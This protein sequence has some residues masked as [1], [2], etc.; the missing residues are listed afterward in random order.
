MISDNEKK[1]SNFEFVKVNSN[2]LYLRCVVAN[3]YENKIIEFYIDK[4]LSITR[5]KYNEESD[6]IINFIKYN[7]K[8]MNFKIELNFNPFLSDNTELK[9]KFETII[10]TEI[11]R[12]YPKKEKI[13][14]NI[15]FQ[16]YFV[17]D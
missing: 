6:N 5:L 17:N 11:T 7:F 2:E 13:I 16:G 3:R 4:K 9:G 15:N 12:T 8:V 10:Q 1:L 14:R